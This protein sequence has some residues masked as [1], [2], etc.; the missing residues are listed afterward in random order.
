MNHQACYIRVNESDGYVA[1]AGIGFKTFFEAIP[2]KPYGLLMLG[3]YPVNAQYDVHTRLE[4]VPQ[5]Q[6][7]AFMQED[8]Y[9]FGDFCWVD[10]KA[11]DD[12]Q[13]LT[14]DELAELYFA[15]HMKRP[16]RKP[17]IDTLRN[18]YLYLSHDDAHWV[19]VYMRDTKTFKAVI[20]Q[21]IRKE[22]MG[23]KKRM[24]PMPND[25]LDEVYLLF[26][27]GGVFDFERVSPEITGVSI[28]P[29]KGAELDAD[30]IHKELDRQRNIGNY[31]FLEY[32]SR[33][34]KWNL[35]S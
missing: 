32:N 20:E 4:Y 8:V 12:I 31:R 18:S 5:E 10:F 2:D 15:A 23:R 17:F 35:W 22:L 30:D 34:H 1:T 27:D 28:Y 9:G 25:M 11:E 3:G 21:K 14:D 33:T 13:K 26:S 24:S 6:M 7:P 16:L 29:V 19:N